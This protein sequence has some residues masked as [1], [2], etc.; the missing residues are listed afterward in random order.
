MNRPNFFA[1]C[2]PDW[3]KIDCGN[4]THPKLVTEY[5]CSGTSK[6]GFAGQEEDAKMSFVS[7]HASFAWQSA[8]FIVLYLQA[9]LISNS[10]WKRFHLVIPFFQVVCIIFAYF[11]SLSRV[12]DYMHHPAD[13]IGKDFI[14]VHRHL[15]IPI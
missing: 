12:M 10:R 2:N 5:T 6:E 11:T 13:V 8:T 9:K 7:G 4:Q 3:K 1:W 15:S 14:Y